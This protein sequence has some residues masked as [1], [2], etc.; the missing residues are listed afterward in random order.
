M[1]HGAVVQQSNYNVQDT[2][3]AVRS[4]WVNNVREGNY[5]LCTLGLV[6]C[7]CMN[8]HIRKFILGSLSPICH[9]YKTISNLSV[10]FS[11]EGIQS[12][13]HNQTNQPPT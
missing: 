6:F 12:L 7:A 11:S 3:E 1:F 2:A 10:D 9:N 4:V 8:L 13:M 5:F